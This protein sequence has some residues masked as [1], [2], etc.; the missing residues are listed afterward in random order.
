MKVRRD[1]RDTGTISIFVALSA[2][3][4]LLFIGIV[5][6]CG[7]R[8]NAIERTDALAQEA[9]RVGGQQI[10]QGALLGGKGFLVDPVAAQAAANLYLAQ[11]GL[12]AEP[13]PAD[14]PESASFSVTIDTT[15]KTALLGLFNTPTLTVQGKGTATLVHGVEKTGGA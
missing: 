7:G 8:L 5:L 14:Q 6:D 12:R 3:M 15:Y 1:A 4:M 2:S 13:L 9:A 11:Y 10:D